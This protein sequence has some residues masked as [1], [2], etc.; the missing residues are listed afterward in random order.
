MVSPVI[1][2]YYIHFIKTCL[3]RVINWK[4]V[5]N[6]ARKPEEATLVSKFTEICK[7][8]VFHLSLLLR[9]ITSDHLPSNV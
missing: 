4:Q 8:K 1:I 2:S 7:H 6:L 5:F 3:E 9:K